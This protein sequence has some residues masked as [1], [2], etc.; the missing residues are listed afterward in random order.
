MR[1]H[2][3]NSFRWLCHLCWAIQWLVLFSGDDDS[4]TRRI[5]IVSAVVPPPPPL[6]N[7]NRI[8]NVPQGATSSYSSSSSSLY[9]S[10]PS[11]SSFLLVE[12]SDSGSDP[13]TD[14]NDKDNDDH[15]DDDDDKEE[16]DPNGNS[17]VGGFL[18]VVETE[19]WEVSSNLW[20]AAGA[21]RESTLPPSTTTTTTTTKQSLPLPPPQAAAAAA[22][23]GSGAA[24][25]PQTGRWTDEQGQ[26]SLSPSELV[27]PE[28]MEFVGDWKIV[29]QTGRDDGLG[30]EY[31]F[32]YLQPPTRRRIWLRQL[33]QQ[34]QQP[35]RP[36]G[37][38]V[39]P[40]TTTTTTTTRTT[41]TNLLQQQQPQQLQQIQ[42]LAVQRTKKPKKRLS[43]QLLQR[44]KEDYNFKGF[45]ISLYKSLLSWD[46]LGVYIFC[47]LSINFDWCDRHPEF[48]SLSTSWMLWYPWSIGQ[49]LSVS[50]NVEWV[51]WIF[52]RTLLTLRWLMWMVCYQGILRGMVLLAAVLL[53]PLVGR[54]LYTLPPL[55]RHI[56]SSLSSS[57]LAKPNY[58]SEIS[59]RIGLA[60][61]Y[62][63]SHGKGME[64]RFGYFHSYQ[65]TLT[66]YQNIWSGMNP[67]RLVPSRLVPGLLRRRRRR[68]QSLASSLTGKESD[69]TNSY[70]N[71]NNKNQRIGWWRSHFARIGT[72][73]A[74]PMPDPPYISCNAVLALTGFY[75][76]PP[77]TTTTSTD[78][79]GSDQFHDDPIIA[80]ETNGDNINIGIGAGSPDAPTSEEEWVTTTTKMDNPE[81]VEEEPENEHGGLYSS[82]TESLRSSSSSSSS[83]SAPKSLSI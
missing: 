28:G 42:Q 58:N 16:E 10:A 30:W 32:R 9:S 34:K 14:E 68:G 57:N 1:E 3:S 36:I 38:L 62:R 5:S 24:A 4:A 22:T 74:I 78:T 65:P 81:H 63:W 48:P 77:T 80:V 59:E 64:W 66:V 19:L 31:Q 15:N 35:A 61:S 25:A 51:K 45:G 11:R 41:P 76:R 7:K 72:S 12:D 23:A 50:I 54:K 83:R 39:D 56:Q 53:Y 37:I 44:I 8:N 33:Q 29:V 20:R 70:N 75:F 17:S 2:R 46:S 71:N 79:I 18:Q 13:D 67:R 69:N 55:P 49:F 27:P 60:W 73:T 82:T 52:A 40:I 47:P 6:P 43:S 21:S 26:T